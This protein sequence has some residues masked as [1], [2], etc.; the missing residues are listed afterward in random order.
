M[1]RPAQNGQEWH[2][3]ADYCHVGDAWPAL[4]DSCGRDVDVAGG[5]RL[6]SIRKNCLRHDKETSARFRDKCA[7]ASEM[8]SVQVMVEIGG[9]R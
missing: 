8:S 7:R 3:D 6:V 1:R 2:G 5:E 4:E 9:L